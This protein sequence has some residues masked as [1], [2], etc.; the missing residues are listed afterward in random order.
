[1]QRKPHPLTIIYLCLLTSL[2]L[3]SCG[4]SS[5]GSRSS[6]NNSYYTE[7]SYNDTSN[8]MLA[9][10]YDTGIEIKQETGGESLSSVN[11][12]LLQKCYELDGYILSRNDEYY[13][14]SGYGVIN[15]TVNIPDES[16][17]IFISEI[18]EYGHVVYFRQNIVNET[19]RYAKAE[20]ED[21]QY[22][23]NRIRTETTYSK[24]SIRLES[25]AEYSNTTPG[26]GQTI[27]NNIKE[28][29]S[30]FGDFIIHYLT[31]FIFI[32]AR[33]LLIIIPTGLIIILLIQL[34]AKLGNKFGTKTDKPNNTVNNSIRFMQKG[35]V[36][37]FV[38]L[39]DEEG[40]EQEQI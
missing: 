1:M 18:K 20:E 2:L 9:Y 16:S 33:G 24:F 34:F 32:V 26:L 21:D 5:S 19:D 17:D 13:N 10:S 7:S 4:G 11:D 36:Y 3:T 8:E 38:L 6:T 30:D 25:V 23:M 31:A 35:K 12:K 37:R 27:K 22:E 29:L 28:Q 40:Y 14:D 39:D 15:L